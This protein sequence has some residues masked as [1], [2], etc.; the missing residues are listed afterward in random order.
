MNAYGALAHGAIPPCRPR[1]AALSSVAVG[2]DGQSAQPRCAKTCHALLHQVVA[3]LLRALIR[4][5][6]NNLSKRAK[7]PLTIQ[8]LP[9]ILGLAYIPE[10]CK[11][12]LSYV[13][14]F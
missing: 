5:V 1:Q 3:A 13:Q 6:G 2:H 11:T 10:G 9:Q 8:C 14:L 4:E 7:G 12:T